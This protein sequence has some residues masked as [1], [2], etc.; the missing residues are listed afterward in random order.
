MEPAEIPASPPF[1]LPSEA[2]TR[3]SASAYAFDAIR[4]EPPAPHNKIAYKATRILRAKRAR[5]VLYALTSPK[6]AATPQ[7]R[8]AFGHG[9]NFTFTISEMRAFEHNRAEVLRRGSNSECIWVGLGSDAGCR[10]LRGTADEDEMNA[11][12]GPPSNFA[13]MSSM[14]FVTPSHIERFN[15]WLDKYAH[16]FGA[17]AARATEVY[18]IESH[19]V[20]MEEMDW[21][22]APPNPGE[23]CAAQDFIVW[24]DEEGAAFPNLVFFEGAKLTAS[25]VNHLRFHERLE[26]TLF[27]AGGMPLSGVGGRV[28]LPPLSVRIARF[29]TRCILGLF[30]ED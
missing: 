5:G 13:T 10:L 19:R 20:K 2:D 21:K 3:A 23:L 15:A 18:E 14:S 7:L 4:G 17:N 24:W 16:G 29:K 25:E 11:L 27:P 6:P 8:S 1:V 22:Y 12:H 30:T 9:D 26:R 28:P